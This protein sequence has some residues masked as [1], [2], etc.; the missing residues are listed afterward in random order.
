MNLQSRK[1][2]Y[3]QNLRFTEQVQ[4]SSSV[5]ITPIVNGG[6]IE[7]N[8]HIKNTHKISYFITIL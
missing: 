7:K 1:G 6:G 8:S 5:T 4:V 2:R 3:E